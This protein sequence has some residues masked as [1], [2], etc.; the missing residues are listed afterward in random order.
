MQKWICRIPMG[1]C[2]L[3]GIYPF[4]QILGSDFRFA[5]ELRSPVLCI[6]I[7][8]ALSTAAAAIQFRKKPIY[9]RFSRNAADLVFPLGCLHA[10][11]MSSE[12]NR[13]GLA[14]ALL[15]CISSAVISYTLPVRRWYN[16][17]INLII[18]FLVLISIPA[19]LMFAWFN[20]LPERT[21]LLNTYTMDGCVYS[22]YCV[23]EGALGERFYTEIRGPERIDLLLGVLYPYSETVFSDRAF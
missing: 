15:V 4:I 21:Q 12:L 17:I 13:F 14:M 23:N 8:A 6:T 20:P 7:M 22:Q 5:Y 18:T 3:Y 9:G 11:Y 1:L 2:L 16:T 19:M 10:F